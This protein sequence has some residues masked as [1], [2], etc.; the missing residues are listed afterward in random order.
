MENLDI[1]SKSVSREDMQKKEDKENNID[2]FINYYNHDYTHNFL[3]SSRLD[4]KKKALYRR[5]F[6]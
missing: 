2:K 5:S 1:I 6:L 3:S 4:K